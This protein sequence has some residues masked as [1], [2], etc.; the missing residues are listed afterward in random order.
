MSA[1][2]LTARWESLVFLNYPRPAGLLTP[3]APAGTVLD[4]WD[5]ASFVSLAGLL[6]RR[7]RLRGFPIPFHQTFEEVNLRFYVRRS[8]PDG[9]SRRAVVFVREFVPR[10][11]IAGVAR[12]VY[13]EPYS[14]ASMAHRISLDP[15]RGGAVEYTWLHEG[16]RFAISAVVSGPAR[17]PAAVS[18][19]K[20]V[21]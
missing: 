14:V 18:T 17:P 1:S 16:A 10:R 5:G 4:T 15:D 21:I 19:S 11:A 13:N 20:E 7:T 8:L 9:S 2:F 6:L 12:W 3:L